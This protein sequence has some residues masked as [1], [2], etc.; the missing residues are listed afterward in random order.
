MAFS[1]EGR[2]PFLDHKLIEAC[3]KMPQDNM[4][5]QGWTKYPM[6]I[7]MERYLPKEISRRKTK[8]A[9]E[10][11]KEQWLGYDLK[12]ILQDWL[13]QDN[14]VY[15]YIDK[16]DIFKIFDDFFI[17]KYDNVHLVFRLYNFDKWLTKYNIT[18][19]Y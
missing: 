15:N 1:V 5:H 7:A 13:K 10:V 16:K 2:Y 3:L 11:P 18:I 17:K 9:F 4:Y 14:A 6:R 8:W 12:N 19:D